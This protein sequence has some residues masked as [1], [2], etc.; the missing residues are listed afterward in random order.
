MILHSVLLRQFIALHILATYLT[1]IHFNVILIHLDIRS[2][3]Y[4]FRYSDKNAAD[5]KFW[6]LRKK[7]KKKISKM[8]AST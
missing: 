7:L 3:L 8:L 1:I 5:S 2:S 4:S 6:L